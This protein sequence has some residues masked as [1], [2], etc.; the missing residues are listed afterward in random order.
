MTTINFPASPNPGDT[1]L[2]NGVTWTFNGRGWIPSAPYAPTFSGYSGASGAS[3]YSGVGTSGFSGIAF[4][5]TMTLRAKNMLSSGLLTGGTLTINGDTTKF[6]IAAGVGF[7]LDNYTDPANP[8]Y[9]PVSWATQTAQTDTLIATADTT[10]VYVNGA[11]VYSLSADAPTELT[12]R[13]SIVIGWLDHPQRGPDIEFALTEPEPATDLRAQM[14]D[15]MI[16]FGSFNI[17]GN[18]FSPNGANLKLDR[19]EGSVFEVGSNWIV[20]KQNPNTFYSAPETTVAITYHRRTAPGVWDKPAATVTD[21]DPEWYDF[22]GVLTAVPTGHFTIQPLLFYAPENKV[23]IQYGQ[24]YYNTMAEAHVAIAEAIEVSNFNEFDVSR[25]WLIVRQG[26]TDLTIV[27]QAMI[28]RG[29]HSIKDLIS[30]TGPTFTELSLLYNIVGTGVQHGGLLSINADPTKFDI[31]AG[32][33]YIINNSIDPVN[34]DITYVVWDAKLA[35][36][37]SYLTTDVRTWILL[38][39]TG[40]IVQQNV[41]I[42]PTQLRTHLYLGRLTHT[43]LT[44]NTVVVAEPALFIDQS[45][46]FHD[47]YLAIG[48]INVSGNN[49][50][51]NG[52]NLKFNRSSGSTFRLN[53]NVVTSLQTPN[54]T[55]DNAASPQTFKY[56]TRHPSA[57]WTSGSVISDLDPTKWDDGSGT[58]QN[59]TS[60]EYTVQHLYISA[61]AG[62]I[63]LAW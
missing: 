60:G 27:T 26:C 29:N 22:D 17:Y 12:R 7:I 56:E 30:G 3:G 46:Y 41:A 50:T 20:D 5:P 40:A 2:F 23:D 4:D 38:D 21:V 58:L 49:I 62:L 57:P 63:P 55:T 24:A 35:N 8:T 31:S 34:P 13:S 1:Y 19:A 10:Y 25:G 51:S 52:A 53:T 14:S 11:G 32:A 16:N 61:L 54:I 47:L 44:T 9:T 28:D 42:T 36:S 18:D 6:D 37:T 48:A 39:S 15:F 33:G 45:A 43:N 59:V